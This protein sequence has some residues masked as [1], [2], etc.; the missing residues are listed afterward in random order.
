MNRMTRTSRWLCGLLLTT[1]LWCSLPVHAEQGVKMR[2]LYV[3]GFAASFTDSIA[4]QT[5]IQ[6][7]DSAWIDKHGF[8]IDRS[9]YSL[10][11]QYYMEHQEGVKN[12]VCSIFFSKKQ[13]KMKRLWEKVNKRYNAA[14]ELIFHEVAD[15]KFHFKSE[16][17][18]PVTIEEET[19]IP[20]V[21][22]DKP[23]GKGPKK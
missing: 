20:Q 12:A 8:L 22:K 13:R 17:Y 7:I 15:E 11:L 9:L 3:F 18:R 19:V 5:T 4:C 6:R 23:K 21:K 10:Q 1:L 16:E 14:Q 2:S